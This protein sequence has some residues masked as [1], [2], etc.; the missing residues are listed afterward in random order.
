MNRPATTL[1]I[2]DLHLMPEATQVTELFMY[3][4]QKIAPMAESIYILGDFFEVW[5]GDDDDHEY[6]K[7]I[8]KALIA[9]HK[10]DI[11]LYFLPGN[12]DFLLGDEFCDRCGIIRLPDPTCITLYNQVIVL[13]HGDFLCTSDHAHQRFRRWTSRRILQWLFLRLPLNVRRR[14]AKKLRQK[15]RGSNQPPDQPLGEIDCEASDAMIK[16]YQA[17]YLIHGH[18]HQAARHPVCTADNKPTERITLGDWGTTGSYLAITESGACQLHT[19][20]L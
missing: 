17:R 12:R 18:I 20:K 1:F 7:R 9:L 14:M 15:S 16:Q 8:Q 19:L 10:L 6:I 3:F 2:S 5:V 13:T 11:K 4:C